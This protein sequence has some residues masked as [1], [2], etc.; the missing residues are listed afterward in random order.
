L[1]FFLLLLL[2]SLW[3]SRLW[4]RALCP[5]GAGYALGARRALLNR[6]LEKCAGCGVCASQCRMG[7]INPDGSYVKSECVLCMDCVY[8][9]PQSAVRF[10]F[11]PGV[12]KKILPQDKGISRGKFLI[13]LSTFLGAIILPKQIFAQGLVK[14]HP[15]IRPPAALT[16]KEFVNRCV[17][18]G[19]CMKVCLT[20]GLVPVTSEAGIAGVWTPQLLPEVGY[21][22]YNCT[23]CGGVC[24]TGAIPRL[25]VEE[26]KVTKLGL[27]IIDRNICLAWAGNKEC[28][29]CEE[30]CPVGQKAITSRI[31]IVGGKKIF[32][33]SVSEERCVGCGICQNKCPVRPLRAI[34]VKPL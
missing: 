29:V 13:F 6:R 25:S 19:N 7:A 26:K 1:I 9:C 31:E 28:I 8:D 5:L 32:R 27:A 12:V 23:L 21:C 18:C 20:G 24:P 33:P 30:H 11:T 15:V 34:R 17:R 4:C 2:S 14:K 3:I 10:S 16:E 22:E